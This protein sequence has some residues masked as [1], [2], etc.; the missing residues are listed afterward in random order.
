MQAPVRWAISAHVLRAERSFCSVL[1]YQ[2]EG[3][4]PAVGVGDQSSSESA[5]TS[6]SAK[7]SAQMTE[8]EYRK[9]LLYILRTSQH[10]QVCALSLLSRR[11]CRTIVEVS[12][13]AWDN[14]V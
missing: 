5:A 2:L 7:D 11:R 3:Q 13:N 9:S 10:I 6:D 14:T 12:Q 4:S 1:A 8:T